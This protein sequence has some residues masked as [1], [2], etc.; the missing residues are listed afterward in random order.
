VRTATALATVEPISGQIPLPFPRPAKVI[1]LPVPRPG[2]DDPALRQHAAKLTQAIVEVLA[3]RRPP[4]QLEP[5]L[6]KPVFA[7]LQ[8]RLRIG[9]RRPVGRSARLASLHLSEVEAG[10]AEIAGRIVIGG[11]SR[12]LALR[13][14]RMTDHHGRTGWRC[15][16]LVWG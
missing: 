5:W 4:R 2:A 9:A 10:I 3:G 11:R 12:A 1:A 8:S 13:L 6:T 14:E 7:Q 15:T 16:A